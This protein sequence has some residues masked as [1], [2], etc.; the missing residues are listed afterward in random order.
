[1]EKNRQAPGEKNRR[2]RLQGIPI[3]ET[4]GKEKKKPQTTTALGGKNSTGEWGGS[5]FVDLRRGIQEKKSN[6]N[7]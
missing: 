7:G 2:K 3:S 5:E 4:A 6:K 1:M